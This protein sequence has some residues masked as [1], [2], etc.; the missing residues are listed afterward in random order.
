MKS[1]AALAFALLLLTGWAGTAFAVELTRGP[2]LQNASDRAITVRWRTDVA[3]DSRVWVGA[4]PGTWIPAATDPTVTTEHEVRLTGLTPDTR[5]FYAVGSSAGRLPGADSTYRFVTPPVPGTVTRAR[6]WV[7]GD[8]GT[9]SGGQARV[10]D[11]YLEW[12]GERETNLC[13]LLGDNAY[14]SGTDAEFQDALFEPFASF[15]R[16][17]CA[18]A[19]R[20]NHDDAHEGPYND[21]EELFTFPTAGEAGGVA[22]STEDWYAFDYGDVHF[23]ALDSQDADRDPGS[24]MLTWLAADLAATTRTWVIVFFHHPPY[25]KGSHDSDDDERMTEMRENVMPILEAF[26]VDLVLTGHSHAYERSYLLDGHYGT[27]DTFESSMRLDAGDGDA[28]GDGDYR[29]PQHSPGPH[30]G[31]VVVVAGAA[32]TLA[33]GALDHPAMVRSIEALGSVVVDVEGSLLQAVYLDDQGAI[34]DRFG[35]RKGAVVDSGTGSEALRLAAPNPVRTGRVDF[36]YAL[37]R[38][39]HASLVLVD[40]A[41]RRVRTIALEAPGA[42]TH[43]ATWDG[44]DTGGRP[45]AAGAYFAVLHFEGA[46]RVARFVVVP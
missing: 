20:G 18:W 23:V 3:T 27:S 9:S 35:I 24:P 6:I 26:G 14:E 2:Y 33:G 22:S 4:A 36:R 25:S 32:S 11:A 29:K 16:G 7:L 34:R 13:L 37:P 15:L 10:R 28:L 46:R 45:A 44:L 1:P 8:P 39:G 17:T 12:T 5:Y 30:E 40:A 31:E 38:P 42:G 43:V 19:V 21:F 41:G